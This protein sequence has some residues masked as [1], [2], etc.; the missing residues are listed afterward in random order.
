[1]STKSQKRRLA[2]KYP[3]KPRK[4]PVRSLHD[5]IEAAIYSADKRDPRPGTAELMD[6]NDPE[7]GVVIKDA[8]GRATMFMPR[9][10]YEAFKKRP[11]DYFD[12]DHK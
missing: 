12:K 6:E 10:T 7:G 3:R 8:D 4:D 11:P 2:K 9:A 5:A 1:M